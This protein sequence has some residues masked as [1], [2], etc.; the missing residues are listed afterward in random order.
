MFDRR[1]LE[2]GIEQVDA[3]LMHKHGLIG[4]Q[5]TRLCKKSHRYCG[6]LSVREEQDNEDPDLV[7]WTIITWAFAL[8]A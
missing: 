1:Y 4:H 7:I 2:I 5:V 3:V 8:A 6:I